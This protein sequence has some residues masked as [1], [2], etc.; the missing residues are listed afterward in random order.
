MEAFQAISHILWPDPVSLST[1]VFPGSA[2]CLSGISYISKKEVG[3]VEG[4][5]GKEVGL[6]FFFLTDRNYS[7]ENTQTFHWRSLLLVNIVSV[8]SSTNKVH[9]CG[10]HSSLGQQTPRVVDFSFKRPELQHPCLLKMLFLGPGWHPLQSF[11]AMV[12][13]KWVLLKQKSLNHRLEKKY[14]QR[15]QNAKWRK[16]Q[17][18]RCG[19]LN[20]RPRNAIKSRLGSDFRKTEDISPICLMPFTGSQSQPA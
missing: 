2:K 12:R 3:S 4:P 16:E 19:P 13:L 17:W 8:T 6:D 5:A 9:F 10:H 15:D 11:L 18:V 14:F 7:M 1:S 20:I